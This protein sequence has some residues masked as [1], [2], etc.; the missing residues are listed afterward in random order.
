M[1]LQLSVD[2]NRRYDITISLVYRTSSYIPTLYFQSQDDVG[3]GIS[4]VTT[5][6]SYG[7]VECS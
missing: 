2:E 7:N 5:N 6:L 3:I 1:D 4:N